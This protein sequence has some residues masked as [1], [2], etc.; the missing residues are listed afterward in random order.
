MIAELKDDDILDF[1]MTSEFEG[2]YSPAELK[3][4]LLKWRNFYR[5]INGN[6]DRYKA[7]KEGEVLNLNF[8]IEML[9][10]EVYTALREKARIED[11]LE[12]SKVRNLTWKERLLGKIIN[13]ENEN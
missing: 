7:Q 2:D 4:L 13:N 5:I 11:V 9:K 3:Y 8:E 12:L 1:L 10:K 6:F